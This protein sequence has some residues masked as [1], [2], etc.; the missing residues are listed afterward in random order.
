MIE[1]ITLEDHNDLA[2]ICAEWNHKEWGKEA[3]ATE[4]Q[5]ASALQDLIHSTDGQAVRAALWN[6]ELAGFVLLIHNDLDS[7]PHLKPWV[8]SL[9][10]APEF[11][12]RGIAKALMAS[13]E[14]AA[15]ELGYGEVYLYTDKPDLYRKIA[16][17]D[18]ETLTGEDEGMLILHKKIAQV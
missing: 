9:L 5:I 13:I 16:W 8:A 7:H 2:A 6:G 11:R 14:A 18:F 10:V 1:I 12:G 15:H 17:N 3:G 4:E